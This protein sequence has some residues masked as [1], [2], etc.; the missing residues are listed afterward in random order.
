ME[1][2]REIKKADHEFSADDGDHAKVEQYRDEAKK[3]G[4]QAKTP[5]ISHLK[6]LGEGQGA[7]LAEAVD[8]ESTDGHDQ[9]N[10]GRQ[11]APPGDGEPAVAEPLEHRDIGN[12]PRAHLT[13]GCGKEIAP[14]E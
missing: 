4:G 13:A 6:K 14:G 7:R 11:C 10:G 8:D 9:G 3:P 12:G 2:G 1:A 5:G